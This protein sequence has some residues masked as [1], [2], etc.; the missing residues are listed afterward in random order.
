MENCFLV[1]TGARCGQNKEK[2]VRKNVNYV[3]I[4]LLPSGSAVGIGS[5]PKIKIRTKI[6]KNP[7]FHVSG[8]RR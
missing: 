5:F 7:E 4:R 1:P 3:S 6:I 2:S 8:R